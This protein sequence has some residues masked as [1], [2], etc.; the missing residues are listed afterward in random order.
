MRKR[1]DPPFVGP[2]E[3]TRVSEAYSPFFVYVWPHEDGGVFYG[4]L[5]GE[6]RYMR[7]KLRAHASA[8]ERGAL[9]C[10]NIRPKEKKWLDATV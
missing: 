9:Y 4:G 1:P 3:I 7:G 10:I 8:A 6:L 5:F 2:R